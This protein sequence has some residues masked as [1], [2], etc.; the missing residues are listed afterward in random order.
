MSPGSNFGKRLDVDEEAQK[1]QKPW[2]SLCRG[3]PS[4]PAI[5][6]WD[7]SWRDEQGWPHP[8]VVQMLQPHVQLGLVVLSPSHTH[9]QGVC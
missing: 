5:T 1:P 3:V 9:T 8:F 2:K 7:V 4:C 6:F